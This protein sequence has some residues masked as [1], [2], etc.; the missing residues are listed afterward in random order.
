MLNILEHV[1]DPAVALRKAASLLRPGGAVIVHVRNAD[2]IIRRIALAMGT[3]LSCDGL[4]PYGV[5]FAVHRAVV[6]VG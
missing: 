3:L 4:S 6:H 2:A 5:N 1:L